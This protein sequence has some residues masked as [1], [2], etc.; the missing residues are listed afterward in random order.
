MC[1]QNGWKVSGS[2]HLCIPSLIHSSFSPGAW[3][4]FRENA[5]SFP[6]LPSGLCQR[7]SHSDPGTASPFPLK[8]RLGLTNAA[9]RPMSRCHSSHESGLS[10]L[11][12]ASA[13]PLLPGRQ[14]E[15]Q[16]ALVNTETS[17]LTPSPSG[18]SIIHCLS[19]RS[20]TRHPNYSFLER[21]WGGVGG[22]LRTH[23]AELHQNCPSLEFPSWRSG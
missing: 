22:V 21:D 9:I 16:G 6:S 4:R 12:T 3:Q 19:H 20:R 13:S 15:T 17:S 14:Q 23:R 2:D 1:N 10:Y 18:H 8:Q 5:S 7:G 11:P